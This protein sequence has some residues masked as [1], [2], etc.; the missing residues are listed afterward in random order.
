V[1]WQL[2]QFALAIAYTVVSKTAMGEL[3]GLEEGLGLGVTLGLGLG[4]ALGLGLG[5]TLALGLGSGVGDCPGLEASAW[6]HCSM[7]LVNS[8]V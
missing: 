4:V 2:A 5:V 7:S 6:I 1:A 8:A 3:V